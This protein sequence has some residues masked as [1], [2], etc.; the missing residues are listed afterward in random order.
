MMII[1]SKE[2]ALMQLGIQIGITII[3]PIYFLEI[4]AVVPWIL[5]LVQNL[6]HTLPLL[7]FLYSNI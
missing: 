1:K 3:K 4:L 7:S 5:F 2:L 6:V